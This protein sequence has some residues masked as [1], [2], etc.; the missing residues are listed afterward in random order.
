MIL[1]KFRL[2]NVNDFLSYF[3]AFNSISMSVQT[4]ERVSH[5]EPSDNVNYQRHLI[6]YRE[7]EKV[8]SGNVLE[9]GCGEGYGMALLAPQA[10]TYKAVDKY[11]PKIKAEEIG[12]S[13]SFEQ[14]NLPPLHGM[15]N[16]SFD[17]I[18]SFQVI[19]H[20]QDDE[21]FVAE[22]H[23]VLKPGGKA[24]IT[25]PNIKMSLTR[26]PWHIREYTVA[27]LSELMSKY[28]PKVDMM[29]VFG[30][31][32]VMAYY[33]E[34]KVSVEKITKWDFLNLQYNLPRQVLQIPYD[35]LNRLNRRKLMNGNQSLVS[36]IQYS[37]YYIDKADETCL[38]LYVVATK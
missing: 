8:I 10:D 3:C 17:Q 22:M 37:D 9:I 26:N 25:T 16:N 38:D 31:E 33:E 13:V 32:K 11:L 2:R 12:D 5:H 20:I 18:F 14:M 15:K 28:F 21:L 29:G 1:I 7:A 27:G 6:A 19:E 23:R 4:A 30:N 34:N 36:D 35:I 24:I